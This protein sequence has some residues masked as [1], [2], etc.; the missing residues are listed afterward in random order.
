MVKG[1]GTVTH[2][3][4]AIVEDDPLLRD[5]L[6]LLLGG[7]TG[8][9][10]SG[11]YAS[12]EDA[13][14]SM[15]KSMP[16]VI[17]CDL[18]LPGMSGVEFIQKIKAEAPSLEIMAHTVFDDRENVFSALKAGASG[19]ILKGCRPREIIE[20]IY[21]LYKGGS[22]MSPKIARK[23]IHEFQDAEASDDDHFLSQREKSILKCVEQ[24]MT[25]KEIAADQSISSHTVH[26]HIK[27]I[28]EKL[29]SKDRI[30]ALVKARKGGYI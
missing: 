16:E 23:V 15:K 22:P 10:V 4:L 28:Y 18:G 20:A 27:R 25:Y 9:T 13:L 21:E 14:K 7:E 19:Y 24:G 5:N 1:Y 11:A 2:M 30:E 8:I 17:L 29:H 26:S 3:K 12:G 6:R